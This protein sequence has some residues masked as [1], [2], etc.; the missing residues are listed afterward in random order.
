MDQTVSDRQFY[1]DW[2]NALWLSDFT[3]ASTWQGKLHMACAIDVYA[4]SIVGWKALPSMGTN[5]VL[6]ALA[7]LAR[8]ATGR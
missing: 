4:Q 7:G 8:P 3:Y 5:F 6:D 2:P 1:A